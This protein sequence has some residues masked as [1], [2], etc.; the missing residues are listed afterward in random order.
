M[1]KLRIPY[2]LMPPYHQKCRLLNWALI[3]SQK[4]QISICLTTKQFY[5]LQHKNLNGPEKTMV[6]LD[7]VNFCMI[8]FYLAI[9][10][11]T[12]NCVHRQWFLEAFLMPCSDVH[13]RIMPVF[14]EVLSE[15]PKIT[16]I[17]NCVSSFS[18]AYRD[19]SRFSELFKKIMYCRWWYIWSLHNFMLRN[20]IL[21]LFNF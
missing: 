2:A 18:L 3:T 16:G 13:H 7:H 21:K 6:F 8:E 11:G 19:L 14:N 1:F 15:G 20:N 12:V 9:L 5:T 17:H 4:M 10:N